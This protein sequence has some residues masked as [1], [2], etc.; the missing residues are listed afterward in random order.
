MID[1]VPGQGA[2][3]GFVPIP[4]APGGWTATA[5]MLATSRL[6]ASTRRRERPRRRECRDGRD[7]REFDCGALAGVE[8]AFRV[9][10]DR[11]RRPVR[12]D[13]ETGQVTAYVRWWRA[14]QTPTAFHVVEPADIHA[15]LSGSRA[16]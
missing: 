4:A 1:V 8:R 13:V 15:W 14:R 3:T 16:S 12:R 11:S 9:E 7:C 5:L 2:T 6:L 10:R